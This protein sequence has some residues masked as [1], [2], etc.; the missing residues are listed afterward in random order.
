MDK[1]L[2]RALL[3]VLKHTSKPILARHPDKAPYEWSE[4]EDKRDIFA[5][6]AAEELLR[7]YK[8]DDL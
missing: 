8:H 3:V 4:C 7:G 6:F 2:K 5:I 1:Q